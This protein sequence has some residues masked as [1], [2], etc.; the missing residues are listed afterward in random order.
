VRFRSVTGR[1]TTVKNVSKY[2]IKWNSK[3]RSKFQTDTK[4]FLKTI[5]RHDM[6]YE[7]L[8]VAGSKLRFDFYNHTLGVVVEANGP[9]HSS[10]HPFFHK[11]SRLIYLGQI[12][13][14]KAKASFC[15]TN[16]IKLVE[17]DYGEDIAETLSKKLDITD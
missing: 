5:W 13:R 7:E 4:K 3:S 9:Q 15:E 16:S 14:D 6:V 1:F 10:F 12:K 2:L 8:P 11:K 17:C